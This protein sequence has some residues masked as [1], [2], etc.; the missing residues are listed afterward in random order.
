MNLNDV[1][2]APIVTEIW[3]SICHL[4][5]NDVIIAPIVTEIWKSISHLTLNAQ[6]ALFG[7]IIGHA[8]FAKM[9][10]PRG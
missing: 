8:E 2:I 10:S 1:I 6:E 7:S 5:L 3:K 9:K 4:T